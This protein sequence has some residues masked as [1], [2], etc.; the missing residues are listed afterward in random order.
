M[1]RYKRGHKRTWLAIMVLTGLAS[2]TASVAQGPARHSYDLE[3][4]PLA[5]ALRAV[6]RQSGRDIMFLSELVKGRQAPR[7]S[8]DYT[9]EEAVDRL[10]A[11]SGLTAEIGMDMVIVRGRSQPSALTEP[12]AD[13]PDILITG[14]RIRGARVTAPTIVRTAAD[15]RSAGQATSGEII[16]S[17]PQ[18]FTGG[19]NPGVTLGVG[20]DQNQNLNN[21]ST[22]NLRGLG[23]DATLT[24]LME[25]ATNFLNSI[26]VNDC[27][28]ANRMV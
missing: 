20:G 26:Q 17:L 11:G 23:P 27:R 13:A 14:S 19:Q 18:S 7:L 12:P 5:D 24:L 8:G 21:A 4:Q 15:A 1:K 25:A 22:V 16:R 9:L 10:L 28:L 3:A 6:G 2:A